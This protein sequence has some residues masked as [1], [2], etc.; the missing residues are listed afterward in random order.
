MKSDHQKFMASVNHTR[1]SGQAEGHYESFFVRANHPQR[2]LAFWIR[3]TIFSPLGHP[4]QALGELWAVFFNGESSQHAAFKKEVPLSECVFD[5]SQFLVRIANSEI[6]AQ[7]LHGSI[8]SPEGAIS[9]DLT[10]QGDAQPLL[11]LPLERYPTRFPAAKSLVAL[12]MACF[13]GELLVNGERIA[14]DDWVGSQNHNWGR[15]HTDRYAWGQVAGFDTHP[16]SFMEL[17]TARLRVGPFWTPAFTPIV[18]RHNGQEYAFTEL[19]QTV[20]ARGKFGYFHWRFKSETPEASLEGVI[21]AAREAFVG[22]RYCNPPGGSKT[23]LNTKLA[24]CMLRLVDKERGVSELLE[25]KQRAAF[26]ILTDDRRHGISLI[27]P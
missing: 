2:P 5:G 13:N 14:V 8:E 22:L 10:Y 7:A 16:D 9:W 1:Y 3:F 18:L 11:L 15:R 19:L 6:N 24:A 26:E 4:E 25:T 23:C 17:A 27:I 12:P 21:W 20:K